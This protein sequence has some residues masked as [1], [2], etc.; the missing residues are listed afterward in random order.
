MDSEKDGMVMIYVPAGEFQMGSENGGDDEKP[1]HTVYMDS[2]WIDQTE[3][4]NAMY[5]MC[6]DAGECDPPSSKESATRD[7]YY[8]NSEY[9]DYPVIYVSW[10]DAVAYCEWTGRR[11]PTEAEWEKAAGWDEDAG[12]QRLYPWGNSF[13]GTKVNFCDTNCTI[14][15]KNADYDDGYGDTSPVGNYSAEGSFYGA[16]D[17]AG[18][19][20]EWVADWYDV[21]PG[22]DE[23]ASDYFGKTLRVL[24]GGSWSNGDEFVRSADRYGNDP[25]VTNIIFGFRCSSSAAAP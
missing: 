20:W 11:L 4:T 23:S 24:R 15:W 18:N 22:G 8:G 12:A 6:V 7:S 19:V 25:A 13:D 14:D 17:M 5:A 10:D 21:Y 3:V 2:Y 9:D 1:I 16:Y